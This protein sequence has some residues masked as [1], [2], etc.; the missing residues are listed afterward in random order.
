MGTRKRKRKGNRKREGTGRRQRESEKEGDREIHI[1][2]ASIF[3]LCQSI[4]LLRSMICIRK[5]AGMSSN[6][7]L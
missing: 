3:S 7:L 6:K 5:I 4:N 1:G 2:I